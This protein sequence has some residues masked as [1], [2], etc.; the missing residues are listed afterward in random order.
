MEGIGMEPIEVRIAL[1][2]FQPRDFQRP[3]VQAFLQKKYTRYLA[4]WPRRAGKDI[5]AF[6]LILRAAMQD[7]GLYL[8]LLPTATQ[9]RKILWDG[10][11]IEGMPILDYIPHELI[12]AKNINEM[13]IT[14]VNGSIIQLAGSENYDRLMGINSRGIVF[15]EYAL[16]NPRAYQYLRPVLTAS[17]G[18]ALFISC[19]APNTLVIGE[20]GL[21]RIKTVSSSREEYSDL[22][23]LIYGLGGFHVGEQFYYGGEQ[24]ILKITLNSGYT[25][26]CTPIHPL[27]NGSKWIKSS[28]LSVGDLLPIQYGQNIFGTGLNTAGFVY[29]KHGHSKELSFDIT[30]LA[31]FY[32]LGLFHAD[33]NYDNNKVCITNKKDREI[34]EFLTHY[35]FK[36]RADGIHHEYSSKEL[37][38]LLEYLECKHGARNKR[39]PERLFECT[40]EQMRAFL[41]GLF[42]GD[43]SSNSNPSYR[44]TI[45]L[46]S[47]CLEFIQDLQV[48]LLNYGV[49]SGIRKEIKKPT[50]KVNHTSTIYNLDIS[51]HFAHIF[52]RDIGFRLER[53]QKNWEHIPQKCRDESGNIY[54]VDCNRLT[55]YKFIKSEITNK[56]R[57]SRRLLKKLNK[58]NPHPYLEDLLS[59]RFFYSPIKSIEKSV[60]DVFDFVIPDTH[61]FFSNG[62]ISHNTPRGKNHLWS[63]YQVAQESD[64]WFCSKLTVDDTHHISLH[65]IHKE[66]ALGEM[67]KDLAQ[68]EYWC[69]FECGLEGAYYSKYLDT[70]RLNNQIT[71]VPWEPSHPVYTSW[72][73]GIRDSTCII[74]FQVIGATVRIIDSY[75]KNKEGL[76]YYIKFL[77][78]KP[79]KYAKH[80][81]PHDMKQREFG[82]GMTRWSKAYNLGVKFTVVDNIPLVDG[83]ELVRS[84]LPRCWFDEKK[85]SA[86]LKALDHY[87]QEYDAKKHVYRG[88]PLHNSY[89][90]YCDSFRYLCIGLRYARKSISPEELERRYQEAVYGGS[91]QGFF[92][93]PRFKR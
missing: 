41:Q 80:F 77:D 22:N 32:F 81:A 86:L 25:I 18:W 73:I 53:K 20:H 79:Y 91:R 21:Q 69:S 58:R 43:G 8:Y 23:K 61:S 75:E 4:I 62:F 44:G 17:D 10:I 54:P 45:K 64:E 47:T 16:Q 84:T 7:I 29:K 70:M 35:G 59:E 15:S 38:A 28:D 12:A 74:F 92:N 82:S 37:C 67:S 31:F 65:D 68:Q 39:F 52:Y 34:R 40:R 48:V 33:G 36:T 56:S 66:I 83:I 26:E 27:W 11:T 85:N 90:H 3:L 14:L 63:M 1:D 88:R 60:S 89:S 30:S 2:K 78:T 49:V 24:S 71:D 5:C 76:E 50:K 93:D 6:N 42:D 57:I 51:G 46:T 19:V 9:A 87:R 13:K 55:G 72:D